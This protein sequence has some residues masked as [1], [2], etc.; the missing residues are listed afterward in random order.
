MSSTGVVGDVGQ[1]PGS[2]VGDVREP[3]VRGHVKAAAV[4]E[5]HGPVAQAV[6]PGGIKLR[7]IS[8]IQAV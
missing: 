3:S 4:L 2:I 7:T 5:T 1:P 8:V 6:Y